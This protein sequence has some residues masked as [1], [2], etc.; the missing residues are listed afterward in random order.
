[1]RVCSTHLEVTLATLALTPALWSHWQMIT[2]FGIQRRPALFKL[3]FP[4][5]VFANPILHAELEAVTTLAS[6]IAKVAATLDEGQ[7]NNTE[8]AGRWSFR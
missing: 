1:M 3:L 8:Y 7:V 4:N 2:V 5:K 6:G